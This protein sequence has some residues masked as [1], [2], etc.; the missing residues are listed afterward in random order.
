[1]ESFIKIFKEFK[2]ELL[3]SLTSI[4]RD[5]QNINNNLEMMRL[6]KSMKSLTP[7]PW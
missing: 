3:K 4:D 2:E 5:L 1:M 7:D 6:D